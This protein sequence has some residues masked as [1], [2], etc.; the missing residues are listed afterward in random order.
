METRVVFDTNILISAL[1]SLTGSPFRC[2]ALARVG[3]VQSVT[4]E[5]ILDEF[6][7][8]LQTKFSFDERH[9]LHAV[10]AIRDCSEIIAVPGD[11]QIVDADPDDD[12][13]IECALLGNAAYV[14]SGDKHLRTLGSYRS[15]QMLSARDFLLSQL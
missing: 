8:K 10:G 6:A 4:C 2:V 15:V 12:I 5:Q 3:A 11:L 9:T 1:L 7:E 13:V 14:V